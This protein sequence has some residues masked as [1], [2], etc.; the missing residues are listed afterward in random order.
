LY[1]KS[2][3][4]LRELESGVE[5]C[6]VNGAL[7]T[8]RQLKILILMLKKNLFTTFM[9]LL[10]VGQSI[11]VSAD[12]H[13]K[14]QGQHSEQHQQ[15]VTDKSASTQLEHKSFA[16]WVDDLCDHCSNCHASS[17]AVSPLENSLRHLTADTLVVRYQNLY[18]PPVLDKSLRPPIAA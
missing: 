11:L 1:Y 17:V 16:S 4:A 15:S 12:V 10:F 7:V 9:L 6:Y 5:F 13:V 18:H 8:L 3:R 14:D 2:N